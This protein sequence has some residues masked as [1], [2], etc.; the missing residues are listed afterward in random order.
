MRVAVLA[1]LNIAD[2]LV[3]IEQQRS[4]AAG[5]AARN[6]KTRT[7]TLSE[8]LDAALENNRKAG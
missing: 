5:N 1:A 8:M 3:S 6:I 2:E 7:E 4:A